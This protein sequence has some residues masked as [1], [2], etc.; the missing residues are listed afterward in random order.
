MNHPQGIIAIMGSGETTDSMVRVHRYL[1]GKLPQ[2]VKAVFI[3]TPAGFQANADDLYEK[4]KEYFEKHLQQPLDRVPFKSARD[5]TPFEREKAILTLKEASYIFVGPGSPT[6]ALKNWVGT[7][8]PEIICDRI[9]DGACFIAA[10]AAA[11]TTGKFTVP[12]YEI[13][14]VGEEIRWV[15]GL[16]LL[17]VFGLPLVVIPHWNNAEGGTHDT[18]FCYLG[19]TR[20][21]RMEAMLPAGTSILG[22]DEHTACIIDFQERQV[23]I[24]GVGG[25]TLRRQGKEKTFR[26]GEM[27]SLEDFRGFA[28]LGDGENAPLPLRPEPQRCAPDPFIGEMR[29]F[30]ESFEKSLREHKGNEVVNT[31]I[32]FDKMIWNSCKGFEDEERILRAREALREMIAKWGLRFAEAPKDIPSVIAPILDI[33]L[34]IREKLREAKMWSLADLMRDRLLQAGIAVEDTPEGPRWRR[35]AEK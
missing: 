33:F 23:L 13:Y 19:E 14:K 15:E 35:T 21:T 5:I 7:P 34:D 4:S 12:V 29:A 27:L 26:S 2:P 11:L 30:Q 31:I 9:Q 18:R 20:L 6:Y 1:L 32:S 16:N 17:G 3:D 22:V 24:R 28:G 8:I 25:I 10:S